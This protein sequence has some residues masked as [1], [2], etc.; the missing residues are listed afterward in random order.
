MCDV[1]QD[2]VRS[3]VK[4][5]VR[6]YGSTWTYVSRE[7]KVSPALLCIWKEGNTNLGSENL[8]NVIEFL[9]SKNIEI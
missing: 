8:H 1:N 2:E 3:A 4:D 5:F 7:T 6:S 9:K